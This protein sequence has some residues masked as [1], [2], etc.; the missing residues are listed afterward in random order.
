VPVSR[1]AAAPKFSFA[2]LK[3]QKKQEG[4]DNV[5]AND[6]VQHRDKFSKAEPM[7]TQ[8]PNDL[9]YTDRLASRINTSISNFEEMDK[10]QREKTLLA[11]K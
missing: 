2:A 5:E 1:V 9:E 6:S 11:K 3:K 7:E 8:M 4:R 10:K